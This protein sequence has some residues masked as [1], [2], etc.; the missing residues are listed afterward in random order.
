MLNGDSG[1]NFDQTFFILELV[2]LA[3][4]LAALFGGRAL[5][6]WAA[7]FA[8]AAALL[9]VGTLAYWYVVYPPSNGIDGAGRLLFGVP[10][11]IVNLLLAGIALVR[12]MRR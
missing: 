9:S 3:C 5:G 8:A 11:I 6:A 1:G 4:G 2:A 12:Y 7:W 10:A